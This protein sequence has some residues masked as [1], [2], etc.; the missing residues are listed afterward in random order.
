MYRKIV[1]PSVASVT[2][3]IN[4]LLASTQSSAHS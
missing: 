1:P 3:S 4:A 2:I